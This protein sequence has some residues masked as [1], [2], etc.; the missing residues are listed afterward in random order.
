ANPYEQLKALTRGK[1]VIT[2]ETLHQF[3]HNLNIPA[4]EKNRLLAMT[5]RNYIGQASTLA[6]RIKN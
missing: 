4:E 3:I 5:P 6:R 1:G 2:Q